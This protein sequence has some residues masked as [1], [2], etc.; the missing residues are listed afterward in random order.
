MIKHI[1]IKSQI[2]YMKSSPY[3]QLSGDLLEL[4]EFGLNFLQL[5]R[6]LRFHIFKGGIS[7]PFYLSRFLEL[8]VV[9][10]ELFEFTF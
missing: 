3:L 9:E 5:G 10:L 7:D 6:I 8:F 1:D 2:G 4:D